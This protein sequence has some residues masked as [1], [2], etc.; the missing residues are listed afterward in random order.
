MSWDWKDLRDLEIQRIKLEFPYFDVSFFDKRFTFFYEETNN[1]RKLYLKENGTCN[2]ENFNSNFVLGGLLWKRKIFWC[3]AELKE[4]FQLQKTVKEIKFKHICGKGA[5]FLKALTSE[6]LTKYLKKILDSEIYVHYSVI[7]FLYWSLVDIIDSFIDFNE[8]SKLLRSYYFM[9]CNR[10][11]HILHYYPFDEYYVHSI[12][13]LKDE[14]YR[15]VLKKLEGIQHLLA[16]YKYPNVDKNK[17]GEFVKK[18]VEVIRIEKLED[19]EFPHLKDF[20]KLFSNKREAPFITEEKNYMLL[21]NFNV[22][23]TRNVYLFCNSKHIFDEEGKIRQEIEKYNLLQGLCYKFKDSKTNVFLQL[24]DV[25]VG[26]IG[27]MY[28][29]LSGISVENL[30]K[31]SLNKKQKYNLKLLKEILQKSELNCPTFLHSVVPISICKKLFLL[32]NE[33]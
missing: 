3:L 22:F 6:K 1:I 19:R 32:F 4:E 29:F 18:L 7:N 5:D 2:I 15:A 24:S 13:S 30:C 17:I 28:D 31:L 25:F 10:N 14:L 20:F 21:E 12:Y 9:V 23:Y 33:T 11:P 27:R 26:L 8:W 16:H